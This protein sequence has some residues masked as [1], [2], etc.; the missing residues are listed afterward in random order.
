MPT[1]AITRLP[2]VVIPVYKTELSAA[3]QLSIRRTVEILGR[4]PLFLVGPTHMADWMQGMCRYHGR[5]LAWKAFDDRYFAG[6]EGYNALMR[7]R[8]F[9]EAFSGHSHLLVAQTDTLVLS[10]RLDAWCASGFS[11][12][13]A[14][15]FEGGSEPLEPLRFAGVG[16]GGFSLRRLDDFLQ[17]LA[18]PRRVPNVV[19]S[20]SGSL[21][22]WSRRARW[23]K[24]EWCLAYNFE[25]LF[26]TSNEDMFWG[27]LVPAACNFF[28]VPTP[29]QA[30]GFAFEVAPRQ[31]YEMNGRELPFGCHA[32]E[33][34][35]RAFWAEHLPFL[36][37]QP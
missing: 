10:D 34:Y 7:S 28:K 3:E 24:H 11:Y 22:P 14:P 31:M 37:G 16:N 8:R 30:L 33:R 1:S 26:P 18:T 35:D 4:H 12:V 32:W 13:G 17:V 25:P 2:A 20:R 27:V 5:R 23:L 15:W 19:K 36:R 29:E 9:Y 6:I 21:A